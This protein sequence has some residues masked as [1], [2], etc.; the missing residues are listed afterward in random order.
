[1]RS[2]TL[3]ASLLIAL[4]TACSTTPDVPDP[5]QA[6]ARSYQSTTDK[7]RDP[8][9]PAE[10][11]PAEEEAPKDAPPKAQGAVAV[12][13]GEEISADDFN[14]E[15]GKIVAS[16]TVPPRVIGTLT[17]KLV[18]RMIDRKL[19]DQAIAKAGVKISDAD[20]DAKLKE[21][22][23]EYAKAQEA[24]GGQGG[25]FEDMLTK[26][27]VSTKELRDSVAQAIGIERLLAARGLNKPTDEEVRAYYD[28][29]PEMFEQ[30]ERVHA[31]HIL[32]KVDSDDDAE[33]LAAKK[34]IE[35]VRKRLTAKG[36]DF[37]AIA[38]ETS[39]DP[40]SR[41]RGG[42]LGYFGKGQMVPE[43]EKAAFSLKKD[44][45]SSP[46]RSSFGWHVIQQLDY[47][48]EGAAPFEE[49]RAPLGKRLEAQRTQ[50]SLTTLL[51][52]LR[53]QGSIEKKLENIK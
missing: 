38:K 52:E 27:G 32:V 33:W 43:F 46:V 48:P 7:K 25:S 50:E 26:M 28:A 6:Q 49:V 34:K 18:D 21:V 12:V 35:A 2:S 16:G 47:K 4:L 3:L 37:A 8:A 17:E 11:V 19:V 30:P 9:L 24:M 15:I 45:I 14:R 41:D 53:E 39:D 31:R 42:D 5:G 13:N 29:N 40:G 44:E 20:I 36:A 10:E 1:M 22:R 51:D 23:D